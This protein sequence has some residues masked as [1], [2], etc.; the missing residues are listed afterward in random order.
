MDAITGYSWYDTR[1]NALIN[2]VIMI[3]KLCISKYRYGK[4]YDICLMFDNDASLR[5]R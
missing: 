4:L 1:A 2:H 3:A 5:M